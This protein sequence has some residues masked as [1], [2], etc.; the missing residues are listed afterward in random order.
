MPREMTEA[1]IA[2]TIEAFAEAARRADEAG[3]DVVEIHAA[4]GYLLNQFLSP[5]ANKRTD[6]Y[7]GSRE[8]RMRLLLEVT[9]AVRAVWPAQKPLLVRISATDG[10]EGGWTLE[11]FDRAGGRIEDARRRCHRRVLGRF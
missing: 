1:D 3:F 4:H 10:I 9:D 11:D 2:A 7:G 5:V 6:R 8:N